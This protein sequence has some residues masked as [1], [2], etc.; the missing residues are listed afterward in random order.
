MTKVDASLVK[1]LREVTGAGMM[2]CKKALQE[3]DGDIEAAIDWLRKEG[4][5]S[6][7]KKSTRT[8][9]EGL[10]GIKVI[11]D[12]G[13]IVEI[14]SETDFVARNEDFQSFVESVTE[15]SL[16]KRCT[17]EELVELEIPG[18]GA[19][20]GET[21]TNMIATIGENMNLRRS[22]ILKAE[23]GIISSYTHNSLR[24]GLGK[25]GVL[26][27]IESDGENAVI[28]E[29]GKQIAMH[30]AASNPL[31]TSKD[32]LDDSFI[33]RE[34]TILREQAKDTGKSPEIIQKM[35]E[36]RLRKLF[37]EVCLLE[38]DFA[39]DPDIKVKDAISSS[40]E[41][42]G[43]EINIS[44]FVRFELGE[45]LDKKVDDFAKEVAAAA[46]T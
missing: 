44:G 34:K 42:L 15:L 11:D 7:A 2:D 13:A 39:I 19:T 3:T 5:S 40:A 25:I 9:S 46:E 26:V 30:I 36:G 17:L 32:N 28:E 27:S 35:I 45:G 14:N 24:Q 6:A 16:E 21:L 22:K 12:C 41:K 29:L 33:E 38:Q 43:G 1:E 20:I 10:V 23:R 4:L 8:A 37:E 18:A 31:A